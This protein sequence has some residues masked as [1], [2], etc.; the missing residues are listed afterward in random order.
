MGI[1]LIGGTSGIGADVGTNTKA[2]RAEPRPVEVGS[3]GSYAG[4]W[5]SGTIAAGAAANSIVFSCRWTDATNGLLLRKLYTSM[6]SLGTGFTAG[7]GIAKVFATRA[8]TASDTGQTSVL[9]TGS[10]QKR[11][12]GFAATAIGALMISGTGAITAGTGTD[13]GAELA[14]LMFAVSATTNAVMLPT[15]NLWAPDFSG[16]W[17]LVLLQNEGF[18]VRYTVPATGTWQVQ[19]GMEWSEV[20]P[21]S[22]YGF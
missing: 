4:A 7:V 15:S 12:T 13:D 1:I 11:K 17:P 6:S 10:S 16:E 22:G 20:A 8:F 21:G 19:V 3:K 9:P 2:I 5:T 14:N 18:R